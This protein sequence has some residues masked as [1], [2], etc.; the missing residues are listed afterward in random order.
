MISFS[1][2]TSVTVESGAE[3]LSDSHAVKLKN[4]SSAARRLIDLMMELLL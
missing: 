2:D 1:A 3:E 4:I